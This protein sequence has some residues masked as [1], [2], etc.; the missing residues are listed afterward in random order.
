VLINITGSSRLSLHDVNEAC[1]LIR[2][3]TSNEDAQIN[4]GVVLNESMK[5][6]VKITV[7]ATGF[8]RENLPLLSGRRTEIIET[9][10]PMPAPPPPAS[11]MEPVLTN[12][13][14]FRDMNPPPPPMP[15]MKE[16]PP[17]PMDDLEVPAFMRRERRLYQ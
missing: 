4:F 1:S 5:D 13:S 10:M 16:P 6:E 3:A 2:A 12:D 8:Q 17:A 15:E 14:L 11:V 9:A 7:I